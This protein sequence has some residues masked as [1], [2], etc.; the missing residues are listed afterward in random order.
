MHRAKGV[1]KF[2]PRV[3][4]KYIIKAIQWISCRVRPKHE[5]YRGLG[6]SIKNKSRKYYPGKVGIGVAW[7]NRGTT[8]SMSYRFVDGRRAGLGCWRGLCW[9][10]G[11]RV[12]TATWFGGEARDLSLGTVWRRASGGA[13]EP[14]V[15]ALRLGGSIARGR[16]RD[17]SLVRGR[18]L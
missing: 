9:R 14:P 4:Y 8:M 13:C 16:S 5:E 6:N 12:T 2:Y 17:A 15:V 3:K 10:K 1:N 18:S 11:V 7:R